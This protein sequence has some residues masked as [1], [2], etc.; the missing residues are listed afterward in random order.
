MGSPSKGASKIQTFHH[1]SHTNEN[2]R[3]GK[4]EDKIKYHKIWWYQNEEA[5]SNGA[6]K[7]QTF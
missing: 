4:Y 7:I 1:S 6:A 5:P 3:V 2:F